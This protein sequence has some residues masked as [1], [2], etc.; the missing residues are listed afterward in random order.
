MLKAFPV[1]RPDKLKEK[2]VS[3]N[4][5]RKLSDPQFITDVKNLLRHDAPDYD[6]QTAG[7]YV[8][9]VLLSKI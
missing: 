1:Y 8:E 6:A 7:E 4:L 3:D 9:D 5:H 2:E